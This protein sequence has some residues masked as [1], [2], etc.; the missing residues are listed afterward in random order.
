M[1]KSSNKTV[2][3]LLIVI[4]VILAVL[5]ALFATDT[6][7]F[8][9]DTKT[10]NK[11]TNKNNQVNDNNQTNDN[12]NK[13][14]L[15][16]TT[17]EDNYDNNQ[18]E[19]DTINDNYFE[20]NKNLEYSSN[21]KDDINGK[22][23]IIKAGEKEFMTEKKDGY[24]TYIDDFSSSYDIKKITNIT[25]EYEMNGNDNWANL[26]RVGIEYIDKDNNT[27]TFDIAVIIPT[28]S[29]IASIRGTYDNYTGTT[30]FVRAFTNLRS[31]P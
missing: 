5:C 22:V 12:N 14:K 19:K 1:E 24:Y 2:I 31:E 8:N 26:F 16:N 25:S 17:I 9:T 13:D 30:S 7:S 11:Q 28:N 27:N 4:I 23:A 18:N 15:N 21:P 6:I 29:G 20:N 10:D 3:L